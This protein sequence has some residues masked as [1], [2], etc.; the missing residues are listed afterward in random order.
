L[1]RYAALW[2]REVEFVSQVQTIE[3]PLLSQFI[4]FA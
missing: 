2:G 3:F 4:T 1:L